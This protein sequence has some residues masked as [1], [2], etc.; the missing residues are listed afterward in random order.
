MVC[1]RTVG[2][3]IFCL[4]SLAVLLVATGC[5]KKMYGAVK[6]ES[7]PSGAEVVNLRDDTSLGV[8]PVVVV[9]ESDDGRPE[10]V[11]IQMRKPGYREAISSFW[12]NTRHQSREEARK[13]AHPIFIELQ[14]R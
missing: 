3:F 9:W 10:Y 4:V 11:T 8:S 13:E 6:F 1:P 2:R 5:S 14:P 7:S 12:V